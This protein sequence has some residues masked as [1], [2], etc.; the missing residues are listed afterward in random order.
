MAILFCSLSLALSWILGSQFSESVAKSCKS[1][2]AQRQS[3]IAEATSVVSGRARIAPGVGPLD[4][5]VLPFH[6]AVFSHYWDPPMAERGCLR[7]SGRKLWD[8]FPFT[9]CWLVSHLFFPG[10]KGDR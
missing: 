8:P 6:L 2:E 9:L 1:L 10:T 7:I 3:D 4:P 5:E